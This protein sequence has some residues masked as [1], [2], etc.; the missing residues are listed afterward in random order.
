MPTFFYQGLE[1]SD[2][3]EDVEVH[4]VEAAVGFRAELRGRGEAGPG[5]ELR[6]PHG[7]YDAGLRGAKGLQPDPNRRP[8]GQQ[9]L[10]HSHPKRFVL[11]K[12]KFF[13]VKFLFP[14][15]SNLNF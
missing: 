8:A 1:N 13:E 3:S 2:L 6:I 4:G 5:G 14:T 12:S 11:W 10:R 15:L 9:G 7:V